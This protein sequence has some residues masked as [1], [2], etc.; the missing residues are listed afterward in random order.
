MFFARLPT[1]RQASA[2]PKGREATTCPRLP[3]VVQGC[4]CSHF[5]RA[6]QVALRRP[7]LASFK[8]DLSRDALNSKNEKYIIHTTFIGRRRG[9]RLV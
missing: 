9:F 2:C 6:A 7:L 3:L 8:S 1:V 5:E 4:R